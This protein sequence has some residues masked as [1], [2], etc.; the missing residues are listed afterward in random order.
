M[1]DY[2]G[3]TNRATWLINVWFEPESREQVQMA[4]ETFEEAVSELAS[5]NAWLSDFIDT[6]IN[7]RELEDHFEEEVNEE[8]V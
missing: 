2:N 6:D 7:W 8:E 1:S 3:W 4:R 5:K